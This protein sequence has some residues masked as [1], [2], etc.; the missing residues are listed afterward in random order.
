MRKFA[1]RDVVAAKLHAVDGGQALHLHR[2]IPDRR[3]APAAFVV[4]VDRGEWIAHLFDRDAARLRATAARLGV[5]R[6]VVERPGQPGQ[7]VDLC[8]M[9]LRRAIALCDPIGE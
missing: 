5:R 4:A 3:R 7:H 1:A 9:P 8:G 6:V 2:A